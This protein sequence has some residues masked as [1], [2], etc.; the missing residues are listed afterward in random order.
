M[1]Y[2]SRGC[3]RNGWGS[4]E[5]GLEPLFT[6]QHTDISRHLTNIFTLSA[7]AISMSTLLIGFD[8]NHFSEEQWDEI[9]RTCVQAAPQLEVVATRDKEEITSLLE[10]IEVAA[11][12]F[13]RDLLAQAPNL[14][15]FQQWGAGADWLLKYPDAAEHP[16]T[17]TNVSGIHAVPISEHILAFMLA[18]ARGLPGAMRDQTQHEWQK[19][20]ERSVFELAGKTLLLVGVGAIGARTAKLAAA[21]GMRVWGVRRDP[22]K[23]VEYVERMASNAEL[24]DLL[25]EADF[26]VLTVPLTEETRHIMSA[27]EFAVMK[28]SG[29]L[30]NIGRGGTV[31]EADLIRALQE[32]QIAGAGLDVFEEEP[33]PESSPLWEMENVIVTAHYSGD[34]PHYD[35][36]ALEIFLE[37][38]RR[39]ARGESLTHVVDKGRGY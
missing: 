37:N 15:W 21:L 29:H 20:S 13:P 31:N 36:R 4:G 22:S 12:S 24:R 5:A 6:S 10:D 17:L 34:T 2:S 28:D 39:Y 7:H 27:D 25:P 18:F 14:K 38:L 33:L 26:V 35:A 23:E 30:I 11:G 1:R 16:F 3:S 19:A 8:E 32:G 9:R